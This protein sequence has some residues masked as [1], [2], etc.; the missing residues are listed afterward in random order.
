MIPYGRQDITD[1][2]L[3]AVA[4]VLK[5]DFITQG[6]AI[7]RFEEDL[8]AYCT[9]SH[10]IAANSA[11][12]ALHIACRALELGEGD[13][14]WT[15]PNTFVASANAGIYC[16]AKVDFVDIDPR[17]YN[18]CADAL[19]HKLELAE[20]SGNLPKVVIP[21]HFA[22]QSC[23]MRRIQQLSRQY[24]FRIIEDASHAIGAQ[25]GNRPVGNCA[26]SDITI[27]SFHPVK[28]ITTAEGGMATTNDP[29]LARRMA[30]LRSH[31][32]TRDP[33][34]MTHQPDGPWYY[35]QVDLGFNYRIT[36]IQAAL[37]SSQLTRLDRYIDDR[38]RIRARYDA[39]LADLPITTPYQG[40]G[41]RSSLHL[42]P[43]LVNPE[44]GISRAEAFEKLRAAGIGV[45]VLYIPVHLQPYYR[46][47]GFEEGDF[48]NAEQYYKQ[49]IA[50]PMFSTLKE[51]EQAY[52]VQAITDIVV[53]GR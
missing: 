40:D 35:Q 30:M 37:G 52:V 25:Y 14:L 21:V 19:Q 51:D 53:Q 27:F 4:G 32:L 50:I 34:H 31:G 33:D 43:I 1:E 23:D 42:Y 3:A 41:Q 36:D 44:A 24:D 46:A 47:L 38:H 20:R 9:A 16:G 18:M 26:F 5:S 10:A 48:P 22:G 8:A 29:E 11:T 6:P 15:S 45:N 17:T 28:I 12:S 49:T 39:E 2:D 13:W 7:T